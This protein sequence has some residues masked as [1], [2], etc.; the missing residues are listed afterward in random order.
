M[1]GASWTGRLGCGCRV[2]LVRFESDADRRRVL[3]PGAGR[4]EAEQRVCTA[5]ARA[6]GMDRVG[7]IDNFFDLGG[8]SLLA[9][10]VIARV[11]IA[12]AVDLS[13]GALLRSQTIDL[14]AQDLEEAIFRSIEALSESEAEYMLQT[15]RH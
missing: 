7:R 6:L 4:D 5:F 10:Q 12:F 15:E 14:V 9:V 11:R 13:L 2:W 8:H 1:A 3:L